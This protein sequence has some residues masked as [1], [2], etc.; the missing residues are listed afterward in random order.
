MSKIIKNISKKPNFYLVE[1]YSLNG[2]I[3]NTNYPNTYLE[4]II[5]PLDP[6]DSI[7]KFNYVN[8]SQVFSLVQNHRDRSKL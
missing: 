3:V 8:P 5:K 1:T 7:Y 4:P 2:K 6:I